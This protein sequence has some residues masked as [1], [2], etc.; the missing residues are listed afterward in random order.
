LTSQS[1]QMSTQRPPLSPNPASDRMKFAAAT[2]WW[3][4]ARNTY[5]RILCYGVFTIFPVSSSPIPLHSLRRPVLVLTVYLMPRTGNVMSSYGAFLST[6]TTG[7]DA[8]S[9]LWYGPISPNGI[10]RKPIFSAG[11]PF[12]SW[13]PMGGL[14]AYSGSTPIS[15]RHS[16]RNGLRRTSR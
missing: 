12:A 13:N 16:C 8:R 6:E 11:E 5:G 4:R 14:T 15:G 3:K 1:R 7:H 10:C 9:P 2:A